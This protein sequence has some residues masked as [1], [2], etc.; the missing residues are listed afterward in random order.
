[1]VGCF[2]IAVLKQRQHCGSTA[3]SLWFGKLHHHIWHVITKDF[4]KGVPGYHFFLLAELGTWA[5]PEL[6]T[7]R[8][9][10]VDHFIGPRLLW[11][12]C[13][14]KYPMQSTYPPSVPV[15]PNLLSLVS[16][17]LSRWLNGSFANK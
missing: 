9:W 4:R 11:A 12:P 15:L 14:F 1:L 10:I 2:K 13:F 8:C 17:S 6:L 7:G 5:R 3:W 16:L